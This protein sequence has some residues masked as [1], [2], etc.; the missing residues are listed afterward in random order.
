MTILHMALDID[1]AHGGPP[2]SISG[3]CRALAEAGNDV[4]LFIHD[5]NGADCFDLGGCRLMKGSG[6]GFHGH[7]KADAMKALD[8]VRPD[9]VHIHGVWCLPLHVDAVESRRRDIPYVIAPRGSLDPWGLG[10]K[11]LKKR[12]ALWL[13]QSRDLSKAAAV[14]VT[15]KM[16]AGHVRR[17]GYGGAFLTSPNGINLPADVPGRNLHLDGRH[18]FLFLS[19][20][21]PKKGLLDL[22]RAWAR[23]CR[24]DWVLEIA[25]NDSEGYLQVVQQEINRLGCG[26][27][28]EITAALDDVR[29]W[30]AYSRADV[31]VLPT[32][33]ENFGIVVAEALF[34]G[35]PVI[36]TKGAPWEGLLTHNAG[37]W[38]DIG[39]EPLASAMREAMATDDSRLAD[40]GRRGREYVVNEFNWKSIAAQLT[41]SYEN[42][43]SQLKK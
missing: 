38:I 42:I 25:G 24:P 7:W 17:I 19:R 2:R 13:Y 26:N 32:Y 22:V 31:F 15:S 20:I 35:V 16:E 33:T 41:S 4:V 23:V 10:H 1:P 14:H 28:I 43:L 5:G 40:M 11:R 3:L 36:T 9:I 6:M 8:L 27:T 30:D 21:S 39:V 18:R 12:L 34:A 37:W 29:K